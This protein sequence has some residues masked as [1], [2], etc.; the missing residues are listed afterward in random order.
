MACKQGRNHTIMPRLKLAVILPVLF[1]GVQGLLWYWDLHSEASIPNMFGWNT[2]ANFISE[3][4]NG[5][6]LLV[7]ILIFMPF[8]DLL[9]RG[10]V[11]SPLPWLLVAGVW[12]LIGDWFDHRVQ[13]NDPSKPKGPL[14]S[15]VLPALVFVCGI[16]ILGYSFARA[17]SLHISNFIQTI[18]IALLQAWAV[19]L[20][21]IPAV[22][23]VR[24]F[25]ERRRKKRPS[26]STPRP[27][28]RISNF[29]LF[30]LIVGIFVALL[31][32][33]Y[34]YGPLFPK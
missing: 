32:L 27:H 6:A 24:Y 28:T 10:A 15:V 18:Y 26:G 33:W 12:Y 31:L 8:R 17:Q 19:F 29:R 22:A 21:G 1:C 16:I 5:P 14:S 23:I 13:V 34:P 3:G 30:E 4:L 11:L 20:I 25:L 9:P 2:P 7:G